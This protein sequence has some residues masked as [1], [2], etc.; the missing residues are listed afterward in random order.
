MTAQTT[1]AQISLPQQ[2]VSSVDLARITRE[3]EALDDSLHQATLRKAGQS[4]KLSRSSITLEDLARLNEVSL[5]DPAH[6]TQLIGL[7]HSLQE[8]TP[9]IRISLASEPSGTFLQ[10]VVVWLRANIHPTVLLEAGLQPTL[11]VGCTIRTENK[12]F[13]MSLRHRFEESRQLLIDKIKES[14]SA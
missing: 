1:K 10:K 6:R 7:L 3:L 8:H 11:S 13:D 9:R 12:I 2:L 14:E 5:M 4:T